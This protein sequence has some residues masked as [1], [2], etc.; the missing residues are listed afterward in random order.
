MIRPRLQLALDFDWGP[1]RFSLE[2]AS[3]ALA[4]LAEELAE[5]TPDDELVP[6]E[7]R[8]GMYL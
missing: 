8:D 5:E 1:L 2:A 4:E 7:H 6:G 3:K